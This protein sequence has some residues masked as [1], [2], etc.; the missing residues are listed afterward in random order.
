MK[1]FLKVIW[2]IFA[3]IGVAL[4]LG[5]FVI[6]LVKSAA[7]PYLET[8]DT[9]FQLFFRLVF[10]MLLVPCVVT[11]SATFLERFFWVPQ[12]RPSQL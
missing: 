3:V 1:K 10:V 11:R 5:I 4:A 6:Q 7:N 9:P 2:G 12:H 8:R